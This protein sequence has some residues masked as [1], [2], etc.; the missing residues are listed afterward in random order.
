MNV[1]ELALV[2]FTICAQMSVGAFIFLGIF[3]FWAA[4]RAGEAEADRLADRA[5]LAIGLLLVLGLI[6]SLGHL[7]NPLNAY[8]AILN[9]KL[10]WLSREI[11]FGVLFA[12]LGFLF[13]IMQWRKIG[14]AQLRS[15]LAVITALVGIGLVFSMSKAYSLPTMP[16]WNSFFT[17]LT[18]FVTTFLLGA[19][20]IGAAFAA[21]YGWLRR[22]ADAC[23]DAQCTLLRDALR[24]I[25]VISIVLLGF[26]FVA[27]PLRLGLWA[28]GGAE[29]AQSAMAIVTTHRWIFILRLVLVF[30]GVAILGVF[31]FQNA[32]SP[33]R[34]RIASNL[35]YGAFVLVLAAEVLGRFLFYA[36]AVKIGI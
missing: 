21:T 7:G 33:G 10:S 36:S 6:A 23:A 29:A 27:T 22:K 9:V 17:P 2:A 30:L 11:L 24:W 5:L 13:A 4:R 20:A 28:S 32:S 16:S 8:L 31:M 34:E 14:S 18:F 15:I 12:G 1:P 3:H 25:A 26:E 35:A 19:L